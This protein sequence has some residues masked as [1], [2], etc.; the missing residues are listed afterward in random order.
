MVDT[1]LLR[2]WFNKNN[3]NPP[4]IEE[5]I[6]SYLRLLISERNIRNIIGTTDAESII[7]KHIIPALELA[8]IISENNGVDIGS[9]NGLP[10]IIIAILKPEKSVCLIEPKI[11]RTNFLCKV[12]R[13]LDLLNIAIL[14]MRG[15]IAG[16]S[17]SYRENFDF[18]TCRAVA[19][20]KVS[21]ELVLPV[22]RKGGRFYAQRGEN[23][24]NDIDLSKEIIFKLGGEVEKIIK[25]NVVI[26]IKKRLT[27]L[28]YP[29]KWNKIK[30]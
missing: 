16:Q 27:P 14:R 9:G 5:K 7:E 15:E 25:N 17:A 11:S 30:T 6:N 2:G 4:H 10:G 20:L 12:K 29:R 21:A 1:E 13:E 24:K 23:I 18:G 3:I 19:N 22:L 28:K 26:V 8:K